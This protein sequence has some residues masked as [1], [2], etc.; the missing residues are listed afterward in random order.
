[1]N[2]YPFSLSRHNSNIL[3]VACR[4]TIGPDVRWYETEMVVHSPTRVTFHIYD[5]DDRLTDSIPHTFEDERVLAQ[6]IADRKLTL[7]GQELDRREREAERIA[8][9]K[10]L[11]A[12]HLELFGE[13]PGDTP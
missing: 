7:A 6:A 3:W 5:L 8:R 4:P 10:A 12:V 1:M 13:L 2:L 9:A 11:A